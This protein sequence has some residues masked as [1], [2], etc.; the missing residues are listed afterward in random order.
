[1]AGIDDETLHEGARDSLNITTYKEAVS[2]LSEY[3]KACNKT[4][5]DI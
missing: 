3:F 4:I 1:M 2:F 5:L